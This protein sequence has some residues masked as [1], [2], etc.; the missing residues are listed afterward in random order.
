MNGSNDEV[1]RHIIEG[2]PDE[3]SQ[4]PLKN[5][6]SKSLHGHKDLGL[7]LLCCASLK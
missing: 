7:S 1:D 5:Q 2:R 6:K 3:N 4:D